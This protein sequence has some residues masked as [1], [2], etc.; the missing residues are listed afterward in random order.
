MA[1]TAIAGADMAAIE[2]F[3]ALLDES[4]AQ[5]TSIEGSVVKGVIVAIENEFALIDVGLKSEGRVAVKEFGVPGQDMELTVG[6]QLCLRDQV[7][8]VV[9]SLCFLSH[10]HQH[11]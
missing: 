1:E 6:D 8:A 2:D 3:A 11:V 7:V 10:A 9:I 4:F 5:Q